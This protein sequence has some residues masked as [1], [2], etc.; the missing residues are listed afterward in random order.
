MPIS[1]TTTTPYLATSAN[2]SLSA[3]GWS[4]LCTILVVMLILAL[5]AWFKQSNLPNKNARFK[6]QGRYALGPREQLVIMEVDNRCFLLGITAHTI[7]VLDKLDPPL[8]NQHAT[9]QSVSQ[10][11]FRVLLDRIRSRSKAP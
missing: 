1:N 5:A 2:D 11:S 3:V 4:L 8:P 6:L 9:T 7:Q 10:P